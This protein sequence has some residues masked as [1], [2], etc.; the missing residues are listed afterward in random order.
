MNNLFDFI[1][2]YCNWF[3]FLLCEVISLVLLFTYNNYQGSIW[4]SSA[5]VMT[6]KVYEVNAGVEQFFSLTDINE[7]LTKRNMYLEHQVQ[8]MSSQIADKT[9]DSVLLKMENYV[10]MKNFRLIPAKVVSNSITKKNNLIT[11]DKGEADGVRKDMGVGCGRGV[12]GIVFMVGQHYSVVMPLLNSN[13]N[14]SCSI[15]KRGYFGYLHWT[16]GNSRI[17]FMDEVPRHAHFKLYDKVV[18]SGYSSV[19]PPGLIIGKIIHVYNSSDGL[20]YR[21]MVEL[22]TDFAKLRDVCVIDDSQMKERID[23]LRAAQDSLEK[24]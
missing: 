22:S 10:L 4:L 15:D 1:L 6:G 11:I 19:F 16:G 24:K 21:C 17:A 8:A 12:V 3:V 9:S 18:T 20:S 7:Q 23:I 5:N 2:R 14:I 13:S